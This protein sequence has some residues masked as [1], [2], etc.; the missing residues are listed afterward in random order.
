VPQEKQVPRPL[1]GLN[2][3]KE[4]KPEESEE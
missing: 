4:K 2:P 3:V 1:P